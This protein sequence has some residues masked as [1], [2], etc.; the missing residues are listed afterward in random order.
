MSDKRRSASGL[1]LTWDQS[2][3]LFQQS[4]VLKPTFTLFLI[5]VISVITALFKPAA[6]QMFS[7]T[8]P[9]LIKRYIV[10]LL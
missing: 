10:S 6:T 2:D 8:A 3:K 1:D 7:S 4:F 5:T 9:Q